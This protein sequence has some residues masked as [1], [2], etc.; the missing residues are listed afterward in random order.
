MTHPLQAL[1]PSPLSPAHAPGFPRVTAAR[2]SLSVGEPPP[3]TCQLGDMALGQLP[4][5]PHFSFP[6]EP[7]SGKHSPQVLTKTNDAICAKCLAQ[8]LSLGKP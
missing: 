7:G 6:A 1:F 4:T 3:V 2:S 8:R 5:T